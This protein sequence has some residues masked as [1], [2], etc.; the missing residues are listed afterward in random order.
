MGSLTRPISP[1]DENTRQN[2]RDI[3]S[4]N[5]TGSRGQA[6]LPKTGFLARIHC[7]VNGTLTVVLGGGTA[8][9]DVLGPWNI[10]N[11]VRTAINGGKEVY[12]VSGPGAHWVHLLQNYKYVPED[13]G[14][15]VIP[16]HSAAV[17]SVP[18]AA[19]ANV[20]DFGFTIPIAPNDDEMLGGFIVQT[21]AAQSVL[22]F[23][24]NIANGSVASLLPSVA[25]VLVTGAATATFTGA[26]T[27]LVETFDIPPDRT[28][29]PPVQ[30]LH[31][32][33]ENVQA[34][35]QTGDQFVDLLKDNIYLQIYHHLVANAAPSSL[36]FDRAKVAVQRSVFPYDIPARSLLQLQRYRYGRDLPAGLLVHD[37]FDQGAPNYGSFRDVIAAMDLTEFQSIVSISAGT[38]LGSVARVTT[39]SR[40]LEPL[41][42]SQVRVG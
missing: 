27:P 28:L 19:G 11:R 35:A 23:D 3:P 15:S 32:I 29:W 20:W 14:L 37:F 10:F 34:I 33:T 36:I 4:I 6:I 17:Y 39:I 25:P 30:A 2:L 8:A 38:P 12:S 31:I 24:F 1:F 18:T 13:S 5:I 41:K 40:M 9:L 16:A 22:G 42:E 26:I 21:E 7:H